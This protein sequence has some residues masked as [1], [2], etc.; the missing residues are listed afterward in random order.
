MA[1]SSASDL[2]RKV[3]KKNINI[4]L[5]DNKMIKKEPMEPS[6][7]QRTYCIQP[8]IQTNN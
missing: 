7:E 1:D 8:N 5:K 4:N 6:M 3:L 2:Y